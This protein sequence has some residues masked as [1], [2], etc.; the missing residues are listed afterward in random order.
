MSKRPRGRGVFTRS[1]IFKNPKMNNFSETLKIRH[2]N[3]DPPFSHIVIKK[4]QSIN[5]KRRSSKPR[6]YFTYQ[7]KS[8]AS[9]PPRLLFLTKHNII[10]CRFL[11]RQRITII[12]G[13]E[14]K[15]RIRYV[16]TLPLLPRNRII[17]RVT[18]GLL[19]TVFPF[20]TYWKIA[21]LIFFLSIVFF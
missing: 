4:P 18:W 19:I 12:N 14:L 21:L 15:Q 2:L 17:F 20:V 5:E 6:S 7:T 3:Q 13:I 10:I 16:N 8:F 9:S 1:F 11:E